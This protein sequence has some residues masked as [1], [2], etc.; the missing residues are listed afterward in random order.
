MI[1]TMTKVEGL[2]ATFKYTNA[3]CFGFLACL[4]VVYKVA[5]KRMDVLIYSSP[6]ISEQMTRLLVW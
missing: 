6:A 3:H 4:K 1:M 5:F 2:E